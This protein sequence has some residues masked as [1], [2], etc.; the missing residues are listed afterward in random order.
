[1]IK[2]KV[3]IQYSILHSILVINHLVLGWINSDIKFM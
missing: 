2:V 3:K 1:M